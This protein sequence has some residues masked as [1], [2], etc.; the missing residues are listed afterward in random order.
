MV[1]L[2]LVV[3][4]KGLERLSMKLGL[5]VLGGCVVGLVMLIG[6]GNLVDFIVSLGLNLMILFILI[7]FIVFCGFSGRL[8]VMGLGVWVVVGLV[9]GSYLFC[10]CSVLVLWCSGL[11]RLWLVWVLVICLC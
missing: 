7:I 6:V 1:D 3:L 2:V 5:I 8:M 11:G 9:S 4:G 10:R